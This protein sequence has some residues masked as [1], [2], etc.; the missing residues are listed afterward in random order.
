MV[1]TKQQVQLLKHLIPDEAEKLLASDDAMAVL[2]ALDDLYITLLDADD[3]PTQASRECE[4]LRDHIHW[5]NFH[6]D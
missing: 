3:E 6:R 4:R 2:D 5:N 1:I